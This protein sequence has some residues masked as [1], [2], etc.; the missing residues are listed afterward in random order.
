[1]LF[2]NQNAHEIKKKVTY[3]LQDNKFDDFSLRKCAKRGHNPLSPGLRVDGDRCVRLLPQ[4]AQAA[5]KVSGNS[6]HFVKR[7]P[8]VVAKTQLLENLKIIKH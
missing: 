3:L 5:A 7:N 4:L 2:T 6:V 1:M 8:V